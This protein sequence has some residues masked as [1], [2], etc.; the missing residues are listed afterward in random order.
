VLGVVV[1]EVSVVASVVVPFV[2]VEAVFVEEAPQLMPD[3]LASGVV[4]VLVSVAVLVVV[5]SADVVEAEVVVVE[6]GVVVEADVVVVESAFDVVEPSSQDV[7][8]W[9]CAIGAL[10]DV[11]VC[12]LLPAPDAG[13]GPSRSGT[14]R[15]A[16]ASIGAFARP[17]SALIVPPPL[18][19][20]R[21][22]PMAPCIVPRSV[23]LIG[24]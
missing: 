23:A 1:D 24:T 4:V 19:S 15:F 8:V 5:A 13:A 18:A 14:V 21:I 12:A 9:P 10:D 16:S 3:V 11:P 7:A 2:V 22:C 20:A 17:R 6:A